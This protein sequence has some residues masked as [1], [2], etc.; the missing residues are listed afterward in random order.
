MLQWKRSY[1]IN[2]FADVNLQRP[3]DGVLC[4]FTHQR[5]HRYQMYNIRFNSV[6]FCSNQQTD[7]SCIIQHVYTLFNEMR[8]IYFT[9]LNKLLLSHLSICHFVCM[10]I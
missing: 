4:I 7:T 2:N 8:N 1:F 6:E 9:N 10:P 5:I 3:I